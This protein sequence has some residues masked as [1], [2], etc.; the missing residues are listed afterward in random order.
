[1]T[2]RKPRKRNQV[3]VREPDA[4]SDRELQQVMEWIL[5]GNSEHE[6]RDGI[7]REFPDSNPLVLITAVMNHFVEVAKI[8]QVALIGTFGWCLEASKDLYRRM[9]EIGDYATALRAIK[10]IKELAEQAATLQPPSDA[11]PAEPA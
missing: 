11:P 2:E 10:Q 6:I 1:M 4:P 8:D 9:L 7:H 5:Q 3:A